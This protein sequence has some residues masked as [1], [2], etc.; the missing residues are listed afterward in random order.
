MIIRPFNA[1]FSGVL[2]LAFAAIILMWLMLR[3]KSEKMRTMTIVIIC[4]F[5]IIAFFIYKF[6]LSHD[7]EFLNINHLKHFN[8]FNEL[9][10][11]L[12]NINMFLIPI[13]LLTKK[14]FILGFSLLKSPL[15]SPVASFI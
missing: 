8:W 2:V 14:R 13:G 15:F 1:V 7:T 3:Q 11:Q 4:C 6:A 10:L 5:N 12:C 9:P